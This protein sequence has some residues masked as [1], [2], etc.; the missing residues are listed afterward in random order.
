[1]VRLLRIT[2]LG[3]VIIL[4]IT[5]TMLKTNPAFSQ[6]NSCPSFSRHLG[7]DIYIYTN[8][9]EVNI[10]AWFSPINISWSDFKKLCYSP[11]PS[12]WIKGLVNRVGAMFSLRQAIIVEG[13]VDDTNKRVYAV[14]RFKLSWS[15]YYDAEYKIIKFRDIF[16]PLGGWI[17]EV[18]VYVDASVYKWSPAPSQYTERSAH[19]Y[20]SD[21]S[22]SPDWYY[23]HLAPLYTISIEIRGLPSYY[24]VKVWVNGEEIGK[25]RGGESKEIKVTSD[26]VEIVVEDT[27]YYESYR[28][29]YV[30]DTSKQILSG[31][32]VATFNYH[33]EYLVYL[34]MEPRIGSLTVDGSKV[35]VPYSLWVKDGTSINIEAPSIIPIHAAEDV[36]KSY[37]FERWSNGAVDA[38]LTLIVSE[39]LNLTARYSEVIEYRVSVETIPEEASRG[40]KGEGWY[41]KGDVATLY[42]EAIIEVSPDSRLEFI[43]WEGYGSSNTLKVRVDSPRRI[44]AR[45]VWLYYVEALS[46]YGD[47]EGSGW[48]REGS[49]A[50]ITIRGLKEGYFYR[51]DSRYLFLGWHVERG[52][53]SV[54][55]NAPSVSFTVFSPTT[56]RARFSDAEYKVIING[57]E[58]YYKRGYVIEAEPNRPILDSLVID[59]FVGYADTTG[60]IVG[61]TVTVTGPMRLRSI[62]RRDF[63]G[64]L[65]LLG[66]LCMIGSVL[67][68]FRYRTRQISA[69][70]I[71]T[72]RP[73]VIA[74]KPAEGEKPFEIIE[75]EE[76]LKKLSELYAKGE[77]SEEVYLRLRKEL[78]EKLKRYGESK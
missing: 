7:N 74:S 30:V 49:V 3:L 36:R 23:I 42:A 77:I 47:V 75:T 21:Y 65:V 19:W 60:R 53:V 78:D 56:L 52:R 17:D 51:D 54:A 13:G 2:V 5:I 68:F 16:K 43:E 28:V 29:R 57:E 71:T 45:Y 41:K 24:S 58:R 55:S 39:P 6:P 27:I 18:H 48:Y 73:I 46:P 37:E 44:V 38:T 25:I 76:K 50:T 59:V 22:T 15:R 67:L 32:G 34:D 69:V 72:G 20:N 63:T 1:M 61:K 70:E 4:L 31:G 9:E 12:Y 62:Y 11:D 40:V 10:V 26:L 33:K 8:K 66:V 14:V 35:L 64:L